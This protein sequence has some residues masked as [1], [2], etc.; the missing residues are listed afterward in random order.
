[1]IGE[2]FDLQIYMAYL[3]YKLWCAR[4]GYYLCR[5]EV[6]RAISLESAETVHQWLMQGAS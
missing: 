1:M 3:E 2:N 4:N 5:F 6:F